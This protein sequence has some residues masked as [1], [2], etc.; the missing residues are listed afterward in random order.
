MDLHLQT[1][2]RRL[3][4]GTMVYGQALGSINIFVEAAA[5]PPPR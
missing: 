4:Q 3:L 2:G 1:A 5:S